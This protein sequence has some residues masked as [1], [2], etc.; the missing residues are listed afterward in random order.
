MECKIFMGEEDIRRQE[1]NV[2]RMKI[3][4]A[5]VVPVKSGTATLKTR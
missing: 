1:P 3:L 5:E 4:G 2:F